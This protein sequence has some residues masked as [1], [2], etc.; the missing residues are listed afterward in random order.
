MIGKPGLAV[1]CN[2]PA[3]DHDRIPFDRALMHDPRMTG[4][5]PFALSPPRERLDMFSMAHHQPDFLHR[6]REIARRHFGHAKN[7]AMAAKANIRIDL[8]LEIMGTSWS[9]EDINGHVFHTIPGLIMHPALKP[10]SHMTIDTG[11]FL[12]GGLHPAFI[13]RGDVMAAGTKLRVTGERNGHATQRD[14]T[15]NHGQYDGDLM[16]PAH[17]LRADAA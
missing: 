5:A 14:R 17:A 12:M 13:G 2:M 6:R 10:W 1:R 4:R 7:V 15:G 3:G 11:H 8:S 9:S 16:V